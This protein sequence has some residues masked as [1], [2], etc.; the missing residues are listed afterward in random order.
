MY[1][2]SKIVNGISSYMQ[3]YSFRDKEKYW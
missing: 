3:M 1:F 2:V